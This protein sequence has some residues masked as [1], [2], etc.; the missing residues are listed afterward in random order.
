MSSEVIWAWRVPGP[1]VEPELTIRRWQVIEIFNGRRCVIGHCVERD[2]AR[3][4]VA[5]E[6]IDFLQLQ[7]KTKSGRIYRLEGP[8]SHDPEAEAL[9][10]RVVEARKIESWK[11]VTEQLWETHLK[12]ADGR[13]TRSES[14]E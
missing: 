3:I 5:L 10:L 7:V 1:E 6:G 12:E 2:E 4:S 13:P 9:W 11:Y 8:P 14:K